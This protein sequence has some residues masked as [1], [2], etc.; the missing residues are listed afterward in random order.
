MGRLGN[1]NGRGDGRESGVEVDEKC[2][3]ARKG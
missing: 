3:I 1:R 2:R